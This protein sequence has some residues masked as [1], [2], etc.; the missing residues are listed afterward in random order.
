MKFI[1]ALLLL[2]SFFSIQAASGPYKDSELDSI[3]IISPIHNA[4]LKLSMLECGHEP[5][6]DPKK[7]EN[8]KRLLQVQE[9]KEDPSEEIG[10]LA[11]NILAF[12]AWEEL[13]DSTRP[14][15]L[16]TV[17]THH[18]IIAAIALYHL[19]HEQAE[20]AYWWLN[21]RDV[22]GWLSGE[23]KPHYKH[24]DIIGLA[25]VKERRTCF[26]LPFFLMINF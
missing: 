3:R 15:R 2:C 17:Q 1:L 4:C 11:N 10:Q 18:D 20:D 25:V 24:G 23:V 5:S 14:D 16:A 21:R 12:F 8:L 7:F 19:G 26:C 6:V 9:N 22:L 13:D